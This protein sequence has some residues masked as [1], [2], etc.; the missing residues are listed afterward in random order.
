MNIYNKIFNQQEFCLANRKLRLI[1]REKD[2]DKKFAPSIGKVTSK[3]KEDI[4]KGIGDN[5]R[6]STFVEVNDTTERDC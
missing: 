4:N 6:Y 3:R 2:N 5:L 1:D